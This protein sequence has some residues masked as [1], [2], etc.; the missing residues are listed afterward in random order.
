[1]L[2]FLTSGDVRNEIYITLMQGEFN[3]GS[4]TS[5]KNVEVTI[6]VCNQRGETLEVCSVY[7]VWPDQVE[8][9]Y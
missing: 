3:K 2:F 5:E 8:V 7:P 9:V 1:M 6:Q 4:K